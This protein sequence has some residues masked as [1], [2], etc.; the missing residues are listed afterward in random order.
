MTQIAPKHPAYTYL[1][2]NIYYF[3]RVIPADLTSYYSKPRVIQSLRTTNRRHAMHSS[4]LLSVHS[5]RLLS[6]RL[7]DYWHDLRLRNTEPPCAHLL[8]REHLQGSSIVI[9]LIQALELYLSVKGAGRADMFFR[10]ARRN[11]DYVV[12]CLADRPL[13]MYKASD[14]AQLRQ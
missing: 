3:S 9:T 14:A 1:K 8:T 10:T 7:E 11:I 4:R 2:G 13:D 12:D 5:S 6:V